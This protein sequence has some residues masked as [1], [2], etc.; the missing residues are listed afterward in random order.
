METK[1]DR[2]TIRHY[3]SDDYPELYSWWES[4]G[5]DP[6]PAEMIP[7][8][9]CIVEMD[10][11]PVAS[12]SIFP[13]NN[14]AVAFFHGL[15]T[16]PGLGMMD[17]R[18]AL[19]ALQ[20]GIDIIMRSGGHTLLVGTVHGDAMLRGARMIGFSAMGGLVQG[21]GRVVEPQTEQNHGS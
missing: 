11:E 8:S 21:V 17:S 18:L 4:H 10:G 6:M 20:D 3:E 13:C 9:T 7:V 19:H 16:R 2:F 1:A 5:A 12:G 15:V 14:N